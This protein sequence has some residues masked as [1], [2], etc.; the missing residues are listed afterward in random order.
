[1]EA[2][3]GKSRRIFYGLCEACQQLMPR[4]ETLLAIER[5]LVEGIQREQAAVRSMDSTLPN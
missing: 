1:M 2:P 3:D 5:K 4:R